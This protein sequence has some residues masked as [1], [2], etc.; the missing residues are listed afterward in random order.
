MKL[1]YYNI[2]IDFNKSHD[3]YIYD[4]KTKKEYL[5]FF[6][7][8]STIPLGYN[9]PIF[10][11][12]FYKEIKNVSN[13]KT[14]NCEIDSDEFQ[15]FHKTFRS[16][17]G[18]GYK[19][20]FYS[21]GGGVSIENAIKVLMDKKN[22]KYPIFLSFKNSFHGIT[23][24]SGMVTDK[25]SP[26]NT[27]FPIGH[28]SSLFIMR[29]QAEQYSVLNNILDKFHN[30]L[31][32]II[33]EPIQCT[34]GD[35]HISK[36][37]LQYLYK[38]SKEY[39]IPIIF[40]EVQVGFGGTGTLWYCQQLGIKPDILVFGKK[41][42]VSGLM[43]NIPIDEN[44]LSV[45]WDGDLID[46]IRSKYI[47]KAYK[48]YKILENVRKQSKALAERLSELDILNLRYSG[49]LF[50]FDLKNRKY[51]DRLWKRMYKYGM[52]S[53]KTR[54]NTIRLRPTLSVN[55]EEIEEGYKTIKKS[56]K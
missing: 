45:T 34:A 49:L 1:S 16:Y 25:F 17:A 47:I 39:N 21:N 51:R 4:K 8:Y 20:F 29:I 28:R 56:L 15:E 33:I 52:L 42:Q 19:N 35:I 9:H 5:D 36:E 50:A 37:Y 54:D 22:S 14:V 26:I 30:N 27:H 43:T 46:M 40:D 44:K 7:Q 53:L 2:K 38:K 11:D 12:E 24:L 10:N 3:S 55:D 32:G 18:K 6:G 23:G 41:T 13:I 31:A 48:K